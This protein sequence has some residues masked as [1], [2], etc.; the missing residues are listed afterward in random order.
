[1]EVHISDGCIGYG[2]S[3]PRPYV[4]GENLETAQGFYVAHLE[5]IKREITSLGTLRT[6]VR[7]HASVIDSHPAAWC[8]LELALLDALAKTAG[9]SV[10]NLLSLDELQG[11]FQY[12]AVLGDMDTAPFGSLCQR[13]IDMG[14]QDFKV[15]LSGQLSR[16]NTR[17]QTLE[18]LLTLQNRGIEDFRIRLDANNLWKTSHEA[19]AYFK[20][21]NA[22]FFAVEEPL[23]ANNY[24]ELLKL[25]QSLG[26]AII[27][28]ES[29]LRI[30]QF[31]Y[32]KSKP[33][34]W[35]INVRV[36]KMG[37]LLRALSVV[38]MARALQ[39]PVIIGA[40]V[41][42]TSLLTRAAL[43]LAQTASEVLVAQEGAVGTFLM[44][45]DFC[46]PSMMFSTG[47]IL[48]INAFP[49]KRNSGFGLSLRT[50]LPFLQDC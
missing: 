22:D 33:S 42:E 16:D 11:S 30:E 20:S 19:S 37:G 36:S 47:G 6:W 7:E 17:L 45:E 5:Q 29:F 46:E 43:S 28:D 2:E 1:V 44:E 40:Q 48:N 26:K 50:T 23:V 24:A 35:I 27:L 38:T 13:Y 21:L 41:G 10:E 25:Q 9:K 39:I 31:E 18:N 12:S 34:A 15:K 4:T 3:C 49:L 8:A 32:L 14:L